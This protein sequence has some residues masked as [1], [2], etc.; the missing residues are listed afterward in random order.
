MDMGDTI[1]DY[2]FHN[3][4]N[5]GYFTDLSLV[6]GQNFLWWSVSKNLEPC[7]GT[8]ENVDE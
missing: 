4:H 7:L 6:K 2:T 3:C 1:W 8:S 5:L